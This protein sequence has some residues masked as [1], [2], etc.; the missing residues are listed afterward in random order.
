MVVA[1]WFSEGAGD[2]CSNGFPAGLGPVRLVEGGEEGEEESPKGLE[3]EGP[4]EGGSGLD[5]AAMRRSRSTRFALLPR[6]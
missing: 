4:E 1:S 6:N 3:G 2:L 5:G